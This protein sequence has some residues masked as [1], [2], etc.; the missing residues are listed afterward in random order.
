MHKMETAIQIYGDNIGAQQLAKNSMFHARTKHIDVKFHHV[1]E[2]LKKGDVKISYV[3]TD[4]MIADIL[5]KNL[6]K[7]K[8]WKFLQKMGMKSS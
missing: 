7:Q 8:H 2:V 3:P 4:E 1:R 5:T 6:P